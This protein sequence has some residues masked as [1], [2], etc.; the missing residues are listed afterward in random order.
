MGPEQRRRHARPRD[1]TGDGRV[2]GLVGHL[3]PGRRNPPRAR[4]EYPETTG[5]RVG[6]GP[7][8]RRNARRLSALLWGL[9]SRRDESAV[10][11]PRSSL[12]PFGP[13][14]PAIPGRAGVSR[15]RAISQDPRTPH[16]RPDVSLWLGAT[17]ANNAREAR[18]DEADVSLGDRASRSRAETRHAEMDS[19]AAALYRHTSGRG[20]RLA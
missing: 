17:G 8:G 15:G 18:A 4:G 20:S 1:A 2:P 6:P 13:G 19:L 14:H 10:V 7:A 11:S 12:R 16:R 9:R 3:Y 5:R